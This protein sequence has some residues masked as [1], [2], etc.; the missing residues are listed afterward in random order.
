MASTIRSRVSFGAIDLCR[1]HGATITTVLVTAI[2]APRSTPAP[3]ARTDRLLFAAAALF[4]VA[5]LVHNGDHL[6]RGFDS[7]DTDVF[8]A[9]TLGIV[10]EVGV[11]A[12]AC[13]R[14]RLAPWRLWP[15]APR[16]PPPTCSSTSSPS[17]RG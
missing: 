7:V 17:G 11:V 15:S 2:T 14:H 9:G 12:L 6:R 1:A 4:T 8:V 5:V 16:W 3:T 10:L 13:A